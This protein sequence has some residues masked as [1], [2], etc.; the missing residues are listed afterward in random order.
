MTTG[1]PGNR[2]GWSGT[3]VC[4]C[5]WLVN[6]YIK[7]IEFTQ[8]YVGWNIFCL[9]ITLLYDYNHGRLEFFLAKR[10]KL[11]PWEKNSKHFN[12]KTQQEKSGKLSNHSPVK[13][14]DRPGRQVCAGKNGHF[15]THTKLMLDFASEEPDDL[16][17]L[18][19]DHEV[20]VLT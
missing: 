9:D 19:M 17:W 13:T 11:G 12:A 6:L 1:S 15:I 14:A 4:Y 2:Y 10:V 16:H 3:M 8:S 5:G 7:L 18:E 20:S